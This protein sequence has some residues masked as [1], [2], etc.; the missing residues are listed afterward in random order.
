MSRSKKKRLLFEQG[1][2]R[3]ANKPSVILYPDVVE[4]IGTQKRNQ[5]GKRIGRSLRHRWNGNA[6]VRAMV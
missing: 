1:K 4:L 3:Y 6:H 2:R 5:D